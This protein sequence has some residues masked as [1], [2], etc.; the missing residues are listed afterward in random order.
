MTIHS[1]RNKQN[2]AQ[3]SLNRLTFICQRWHR[4][5]DILTIEHT[6]PNLSAVAINQFKLKFAW[7]VADKFKK[8]STKPK[9]HWCYFYQ[10]I[11]ASHI[12]D[13]GML[14]ESYYYS[15]QP[16][17]STLNLRLNCGNPS[18]KL[19]NMSIY[20]LLTLIGVFYYSCYI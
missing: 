3:C 19:A 1:T 6:I 20:Q 8:V 7:E 16:I 5:S 4:S 14:Y 2:N 11:Y 12:V 17:L 10:T 13:W 15:S 18:S 9:T